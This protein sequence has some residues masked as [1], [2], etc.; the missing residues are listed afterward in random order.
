MPKSL[1]AIHLVYRT[2]DLD[3]LDYILYRKLL[4][5]L[6]APN[7]PIIQEYTSELIRNPALLFIA[8]YIE[9]RDQSVSVNTL[10]CISVNYFCPAKQA[11]L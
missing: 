1:L 11:L 5:H 7:L 10:R 4:G 9:M 2:R 3:L 6:K 8:K